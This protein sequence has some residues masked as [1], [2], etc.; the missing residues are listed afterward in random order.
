[1]IKNAKGQAVL[2]YVL[3]TVMIFIVL[4]S[5]IIGVARNT[6]KFAQNYFG[7]YFQCLLELGELPALG[8]DNSPDTE[9]DDLYEPFSFT[10]GRPP[11]FD[12]GN[13]NGIG[14]NSDDGSGS[15]KDDSQ[16]DENSNA[17]AGSETGSSGSSEAGGNVAA[18]NGS[19]G[20]G[21]GGR[22]KK[23]PL[24]AADKKGV[25]N[26]ADGISGA[27]SGTNNFQKDEAF[28][29]DGSGRTAYVPIYGSM[30]TEKEDVG[31]KGVVKADVPKNPEEAL[32]G[33]RVPVSVAK[34][35]INGDI[36]DEGVTFPDIIKTLIIVAII[37]I[38]VVFFGGQV[39]Q[40]NKS[41]D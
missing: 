24:S 19:F 32:R 17:N 40:Y 3:L 1:M 35:K 21:F 16:S 25:G 27:P 18:G 34:P 10:D 14:N 26:N 41:K 12:S 23:V 2:E 4:L 11:N 30:Q 15:G 13:G 20:E 33:K 22:V 9:C 5:V 6:Q 8:S 29:E 36:K 37:L 7:A 31:K 28:G 38:I 39:M